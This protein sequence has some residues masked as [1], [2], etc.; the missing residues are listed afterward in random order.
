MSTAKNTATQDDT[1]TLAAFDTL[2]AKQTEEEEEDAL[3][4]FDTFLSD[5]DREQGDDL[6]STQ[7]Y[8]GMSLTEAEKK[9]EKIKTSKDVAPITDTNMLSYTNPATGRKEIIP[10]PSGAYVDAATSAVGDIW[11][12][13]FK[14]AGE[15]FTD[16]KATVGVTDKLVGGMAESWGAI[17]QT[18]A[19]TGEKIGFDG[20]IEAAAENTT[21]IDTADD[22]SDSLLTD[23]GPAV[24]A[25]TPATKVNTLLQGSSLLIRGLATALTAEVGASAT[26]STG[27]GTAFV[28]EGASVLPIAD[29]IDLGSSEADTILTHRINTLSEGLAM[30]GILGPLIKVGEEVVSLATKFVVLPIVTGLKGSDEAISRRAYGELMQKITMLDGNRGLSAADDARARQEVIQTLKDNKDIFISGLNTLD[31]NEAVVIDTISALLRGVDDPE[32]RSVLAGLRQGHLAARQGSGQTIAAME[33]PQRALEGEITG[34]AQQVGGETP[35]QQTGTI[36]GAA[37]EF[38]EAGRGLIRSADDAVEQAK[39]QYNTSVNNLTEDIGTDLNFG[40]DLTRLSSVV[41]TDIPKLKTGKREDIQQ[42]VKDAYESMNQKKN[43][44]YADISGGAVEPQTLREIFSDVT[45]ENI[46]AAS[47]VVMA[48]SP[49]RKLMTLVKPKEIVEDVDGKQISRIETDDETTARIQKT[50]DEEGLDFGFFYRQIRPELSQAASDVYNQ[51]PAASRMLRK[52]VADID[53]RM[54]DDVS[55]NDVDLADAATEAKRYYKEDYA[56]VWRSQGKMQDYSDIHDSTL[57]RGEGFRRGFE[58]QTEALTKDVLT[59]YNA[60]SV[61][62]LAQAIAVVDD[63]S[64]IADYMILDVINN[65]AN[66]IRTGGVDSVNFADVTVL[67]Q[68]YAEVL[69]K[70]FP[71]KAAQLNEFLKRIEKASGDKAEMGRILAANAD[72]MAKARQAVADSELSKFL[73]KTNPDDLQTTAGPYAVFESLLQNKEDG[74]GIIK[75]LVAR[76]EKMD[77]ARQKIVIDGMKTAYMRFLRDKIFSVSQES[78]GTSAIKQANVRATEEEMNTFIEMGASVFKDA[79][80]YME[81]FTSLLEVAGQISREKKAIPVAGMSATTFL[82]E[83]RTASGRLINMTLGPLNRLGTKVR[84]TFGMLF[85][86]KNPT[87]RAQMILDNLYADPNYIIELSKKYDRTP[88][89]EA[90]KQQLLSALLSSV[91]KTAAAATGSDEKQQMSDLFPQ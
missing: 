39:A 68:Q 85:E 34:T 88:M 51:S 38:A 24:V 1:A 86:G 36:T 6:I 21:N 33:G 37:E 22:L 5:A 71:T 75:D 19:A 61:D 47:G 53:G 13:E 72:N 76:A 30:S 35:T 74:A 90:V 3:A 63:P 16:P 8:E 12:G 73:R 17:F 10:A 31:E 4:S 18:V 79:P 62:S 77:P 2:L 55:V 11:D 32:A 84:A 29:G 23:A 26:M 50:L 58:E 20:L 89:D 82:K 14:K 25:G 43:D 45:E 91:P 59:G 57:G 48:S 66:D 49:L 15:R 70:T 56:P 54:V 65:L 69:N 7:M 52:V 83:A 67:V 46:S 80:G 64:A 87:A 42:F 41:G 81:G 28:G 78:G 60:S 40:D 44:L 9:Y 27:E